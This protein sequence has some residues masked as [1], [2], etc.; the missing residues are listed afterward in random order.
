MNTIQLSSELPR[1]VRLKKIEN[2]DSCFADLNDL[3]SPQDIS[4]ITKIF[5]GQIS[6]DE[7]LTMQGDWF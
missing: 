2:S 6:R 7:I 4:G 5:D 3:L 1:L